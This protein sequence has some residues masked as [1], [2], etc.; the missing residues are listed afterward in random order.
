[1]KKAHII[2]IAIFFIA[3]VSVAVAQNKGGSFSSVNM[4]SAWYQNSFALVV[5][6]NSYSNGWGRLSAGVSDAK[7]MAKVLRER[8][9]TVYELYNEKAKGA[10][11]I[12]QLRKAARRTGH[13]DRFV[14]YYSGHGYTETSAWENSQT[15]YIVPVEGRSGDLTGYISMN[16]VRDEIISHCKARHV[17]LIMDSCFSGTLLTR[18]SIN[19]GEVSDFLSKRGIYGI[20]AGM[21]DQP[22]LDGLFTN[23]LLDGL[24]GNADF[25][26]NG[27]VTFK[28]LGLYAEQ[29]VKTR[30]HSQT[31]D[32]GVM[33][34]A[35][36][37]VFARPGINP[38]Y[39]ASG[40]FPVE[41]T[42]TPPETDYDAIA[43]AEERRANEKRANRQA[44][45]KTITDCF[46][47]VKGY[48]QSLEYSKSAKQEVY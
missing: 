5:G 10:E 16:Q 1:M 12:K 2:F 22:A 11:I 8:G 38:L 45:Q 37:F 18:A 42:Y 35:G 19:D 24:E 47:K 23:V 48:K 20:T 25:D 36:Q 3:A 40:D 17:L 30:N 41:S 4:Q 13:N 15:G 27:Y 33:Y 39:A 29:N 7:K 34:G 31:P 44:R 32:Y 14:F 28:E 6:I 21:Q 9:F 46:A 26:N 43:L